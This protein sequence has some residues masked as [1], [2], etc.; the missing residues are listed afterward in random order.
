M[1]QNNI[2]DISLF[3][4]LCGVG[5]AAHCMSDH[6][7]RYQSFIKSLNDYIVDIADSN[8]LKYK[9]LPLNELFYDIMYGLTGT[10]TYLLNFHSEPKVKK[11]LMHILQY[12]TDL[13]KTGDNGIPRFAIR[14]D[15][16]QL[17]PLENSPEIRYSKLRGCTR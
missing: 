8:I 11:T 4:G 13:C 1:G 9:E 14:A 10:A 5:F 15:E 2:Y 3:D 6:G 17:F 16:S 12:L 7:K